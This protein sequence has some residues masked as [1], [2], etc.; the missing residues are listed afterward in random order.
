MIEGSLLGNSHRKKKAQEILTI[1]RAWSLVLV[2]QLPH[3]DFGKRLRQRGRS[4]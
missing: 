4:N 2:A 1:P 3:G